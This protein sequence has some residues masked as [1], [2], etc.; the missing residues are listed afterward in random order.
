MA[1]M[2][3]FSHQEFETTLINMLRAQMEKVANM[4]AQMRKENSEKEWRRNARNQKL[5]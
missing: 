1:E 4:R 3:E 2:L 5:L